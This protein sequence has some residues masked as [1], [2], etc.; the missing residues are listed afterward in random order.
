MKIVDIEEE[1]LH[2][3]QATLEISMDFSGKMSFM[4]RS[5]IYDKCLKVC[6]RKLSYSE[7][8]EISSFRLTH[9]LRAIYT[10]L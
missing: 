6:M 2:V 7:A 4:I 8:P 9:F 1:R 5:K 3:F 10:I